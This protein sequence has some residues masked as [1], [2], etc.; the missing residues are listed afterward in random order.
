[1]SVIN[2]QLSIILGGKM[3]F[4]QII[5]V[6]LVCW[7]LFPSQGNAQEKATPEEVVSKIHEAVSYLSQAGEEGLES[8]NERSGPWVFKD[9]YAFVFDCSQGTII[10]HPIRPKLVGKNL[11]GLK[12][13]KGNYFF[14]QLC[15]ASKKE[16][17]GWV[18]YWW[19]KPG[20]EKPS[21]K[22]SL[23]IQIPGMPYQVGSGIYDETKSL[24]DLE[25]LIK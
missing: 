4:K 15:E 24:E 16:Q 10:A 3:K 14:V 20:E 5:I 19:P 23:L 2:Y 17:G 21:R 12:D 6:L 18:E 7:I 11:M 9:T 22:I 8:F 25:Q 1:L 13:I